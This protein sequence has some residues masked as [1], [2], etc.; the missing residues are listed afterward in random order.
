[1]KLSN[2]RKPLLLLAVLL[3]L[4]TA[5]I[6]SAL[7]GKPVYV[8][9]LRAA[10]G[11]ETPANGLALFMVDQSGEIVYYRLFVDAIENVNMA[12]IHVSDVPK[13]TGPAA[14]WLYPDAPPPTTI[15]G[16]FSGL[17]ARGNFTSADF[18]GPLAGMSMADLFTAIADDRAYVNVHTEQNPAGEITGRLRER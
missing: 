12:H 15:P 6:G 5:T 18:V 17:L 10:P 1:M 8:A 13:G 11:V 9:K 16:V 14:V 7:A 4:L 2:L 3:V